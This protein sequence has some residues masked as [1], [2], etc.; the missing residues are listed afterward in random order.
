MFETASPRTSSGNPSGVPLR[1]RAGGRTMR[2]RSSTPLRSEYLVA[3]ARRSAPW[4][5][6]ASRLARGNWMHGLD[7]RPFA[8]LMRTRLVSLREGGQKS[9]RESIAEVLAGGVYGRKG[10]RSLS[11]W[12]GKANHM[13]FHGVVLGLSDGIPSS[14]SRPIEAD[15]F[16]AR[17]LTSLIFSHKYITPHCPDLRPFY[18]VNGKFYA[19]L[20]RSRMRTAGV[21]RRLL[22][23]GGN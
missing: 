17:F 11:G 19:V 21:S 2:A 12:R 10:L 1:S 7:G 3:R 8:R 23:L 9:G 16:S 5:R 22:S 6:H 18:A 20:H 15:T 4:A 14:P 13:P